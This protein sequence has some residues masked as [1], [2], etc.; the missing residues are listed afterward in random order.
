MVWLALRRHEFSES[1]KHTILK[2]KKEV[3]IFITSE[4]I[5]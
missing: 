3:S 2:E 5:F 1:T 4:E